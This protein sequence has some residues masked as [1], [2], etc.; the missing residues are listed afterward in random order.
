ML[1][2]RACAPLLALALIVNVFAARLE[3]A[4]SASRT[5][6]GTV[7]VLTLGDSITWPGLWQAEMCRQ[8]ANAAGL[9]CDVRNVAVGGT[10]CGYWPSRIQA[11]LNQHQPDLVVIACGTNDDLTVL[12]ASAA[13]GT[14]WRQTVETIYTHRTPPI[15]IVPV[16]IQYSDP[17]LVPPWVMA[18]EPLVNDE[19][20]RNIQLYQWAGWFPGVVDWQVIPADAVHLDGGGFHPTPVG[21]LK[22][23]Y[24]AYERIAPGMGW[25]QSAE[26]RPCGLAGHRP[27]DV[28]PAFE[29][30]P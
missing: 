7:R 15:P 20:Y 27:G 24:L 6:V 29:P 10:G 18:S 26:P 9:T 16:L 28:R 25:P 2:R 5:T 13:L 3:S 1:L 30:C 19:I 14:A 11:L 22:A 21:Q 4:S 17:F 8:L 12:G 23:G